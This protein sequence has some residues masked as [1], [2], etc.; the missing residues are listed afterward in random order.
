ML[1]TDSHGGC[2][3]PEPGATAYIDGSPKPCVPAAKPQRLFKYLIGDN[4]LE[5]RIDMTAPV[6]TTL[7]LDQV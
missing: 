1:D 6:V 3:Q 2:K 4:E 7:R 5:A